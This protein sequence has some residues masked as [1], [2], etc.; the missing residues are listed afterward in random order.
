MK[1]FASLIVA[2]SITLVGNAAASDS[3]I[4]G[5][6]VANAV[7]NPEAI[8]QQKMDI[9]TA[10]IRTRSQLQAYLATTPSSSIYKMSPS[11]RSNFVASLVFTKNG[12]GS[13]SYIDL[14]G[15][16]VRDAYSILSLFGAQSTIGSV[17]G[18]KANTALD[19]AIAERVSK[20]MARP[21]SSLIPFTDPARDH[22]CTIYPNKPSGVCEYNYG[23][24]CMDGC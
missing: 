11:A 2:I 17:P 5:I 8:S 1:L 22:I 16:S 10:A 18:L 15:L 14:A 23:S 21:N 24:H 7:R 20:E 4:T 3:Q 6:S 12:L 9:V 19:R 13:Y